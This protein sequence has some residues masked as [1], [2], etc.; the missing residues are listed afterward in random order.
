[1]CKP[2]ENPALPV[3]Q[4]VE[5]L[6]GRMTTAEKVKQLNCTMAFG[7]GEMDPGTMKLDQGMGEMAVMGKDPDSLA[8][9]VEAIQKYVKEHTRLG[10]PVLFHCEALSGPV[11]VGSQIL[12]T[13][14]TLGATFMP[15][16]VR[17][18]C[19]RTRRQ[20]KAI[21]I[22]Q[23]LSPVVD[24]S[25][26]YR[27]GRVSETY[28]GDPT[29]C[30]QMG[31]AFVQGLQGED[32]TQG[33]A[34]T[35]KHFLGYGN[36]YGGL[37][38]AKSLMDPWE[39]RE[40][41]A[42]PFEA[43][44]R[45]GHVCSV[46]NS[47]SEYNGQPICS[48]KEVLTDLLRQE[49]GF[50]GL[51]VSDYMSVNRLVNVFHTAETPE[52]AGEKCLE[53]GLDVEC[54]NPYG[55]NDRMVKDLEEGKADMAAL[56]RSVRRILTLKFRLGLFENPYP[57]QEE[58]ARAFDP[59][60]GDKLARLA[61]EKA[62][63][64][65]RNAGLLPLEDRKLKLAVIGPMGN[66]PRSTYADYTWVGSVEMALGGSGMA[67]VGEKISNPEAASP[68][69][70]RGVPLHAI[71]SMIRSLCPKLRTTYEALK[72]RFASVTYTE[73]CDYLAPDTS[74]F[75]AALEAA[76]Q[77]DVV[78][79]TVG[80]R[81][82]WGLFNTSGEGVDTVNAGL[83]G[84]Q[85]DLVKAVFSVNP[86]MIVAHT[87]A[88]PLVSTWIYDHVPAVVEGFLGGTFGGLALAEAITGEINPGGR[89]QIDVPRS[90][91][92]GTMSH[93]LHCGTAFDS[94][95]KQAV[96]PD[97][98]I[99]DSASPLLPFGYGL[100]YTDF[101]YSKMTAALDSDN[102]VTV[103]ATVT[104]TGIRAGDEVVQL[105]AADLIGSRIRPQQELAGFCRV[106]LQPGESRTVEFRFN[107]D[108]LAFPDADNRWV[109]EAG[110]FKLSL[111][112][113]SREKIW[114]KTVTVPETRVIDPALRD[115]YAQ[116]RL[117]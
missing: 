24:V 84:V 56:N 33:V 10:I 35:L 92:H 57:D 61:A 94:F 83:P 104:N 109:V 21:G 14:I 36:T 44:I 85:E 15:E 29:L 77:A 60:P 108:Q 69:S 51:V 107:L 106:S 90:T 52:Q 98:Y 112:R 7:D 28:G 114:E 55:Y 32:L 93:Y 5:D 3:E 101:E 76:R 103:H 26:D 91:A 47:Y 6:L 97:G 63:T 115:F 49:L 89:L 17:E 86:R 4:R 19:D 38:M 22:R 23:A 82:G 99:N 42:K 2:Y 39:M 102:T 67:G 34:A 43:A 62:V 70:Q 16:I 18:M 50:D 20:M 54:P 105:Y 74:G 116:S 40:T 31:T 9:S 88:H 46:M 81:N 87:D 72:D 117:I 79:M 45:K 100:S 78:I 37:N 73:G 30:A 11:V 96:N 95:R 12:P 8:K 53:A 13:S 68:L 58:L 27:W 64:L 1:M 41:Y 66:A 111:G 48:S 113:D 59:E 71:D 25:R 75:A 80:G 110:A 65:T